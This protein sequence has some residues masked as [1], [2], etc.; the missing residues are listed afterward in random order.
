MHLKSVR[1]AEPW[2]PPPLLLAAALSRQLTKNPKLCVARNWGPAAGRPARP[3]A[4]AK[5][6]LPLKRV[7]VRQRGLSLLLEGLT[8]S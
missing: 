8:Q 7:T 6:T 1:L 5:A 3:A 2:R 4:A